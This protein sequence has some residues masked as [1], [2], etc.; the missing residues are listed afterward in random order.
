[1]KSDWHRYNLKRRVASLP[2]ITAEAFTEK[3]LQARAQ[4]DAEAGKAFF[5]RSC[6]ICEKTY[7][8]ENS[9]QNHLSSQKHR[10]R[11]ARG[12]LTPSAIPDETSSVM[13]S[14]F[15][16]GE[17]VAAHRDDDDDDDEDN[18][19]DSTSVEA[20]FNQVVEGLQ[21]ATVSGTRPSPVKRPS[22]PQ[23]TIAQKDD[24]AK[25]RDSGSSTPT[26]QQP[27]P[28][29]ILQQC[30][31]CRYMSPTIRLNAH[32]MERFHGMVIP[33]KEYLVDLEGLLKYLTAKI[34]EGFECLT[35]G[36]MKSNAFAVQTHMR[37]VGHCTIPYTTEDEQ[38]DIGEFYDFRS[39]Y[40]DDE[41]DSDD[42]EN[43]KV[44]G[45]RKL[46]AKRSQTVTDE[47]GEEVVGEDGW[48]TDSSASSYD[49]EELTAVPADDRQ[50][51]YERLNKSHHHSH[52]DP[53]HHHMADGWHSHAHK[54]NARAVFHDDYE[55]HL[56]SGKSVGHRSL[57]RYYR[58]N[59]HNYPTPDER[60]D[61]ERL[62]LEN[63]GS[64]GDRETQSEGEGEGEA[65][66]N[67]SRA[68]IPRGEQGLAGVTDQ[69]KEKLA[70]EVHQSRK[71]EHARGAKRDIAFG[72]KLNK[73]KNYYYRYERGG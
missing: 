62:A 17:P 39:T 33:E 40:S 72:T 71:M 20:E 25:D 3:V 30:L 21:K 5:E 57:N 15:S 8:S 70:R 52:N 11:E 54:H 14:T 10:A 53:R 36:K 32:H 28:S 50:N 22:N 66:G 43:E 46:G 29:T 45:G 23:A 61:R 56:P 16:L 26:P 34:Y 64:H 69:A 7:Y 49:S 55:L 13:S 58:Q 27:D 47:N 2:P 37:D 48:E 44:G 60:S 18:G 38:L 59:L 67:H 24:D 41:D 19:P 42:E 35:C 6:H 4:T 63:G 1:M 31:F 65:S 51:Q 73:Q 68:V 12:V 9:Y